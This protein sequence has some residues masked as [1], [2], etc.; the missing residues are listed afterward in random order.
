MIGIGT[1]KLKTSFFDNDCYNI[2]RRGLE[3][4]YRI[5]D[6]AQLY[7]NE[8][9]VA[10]AIL[11]SGVDRSEIVLI[12]KVLKDHINTG[13][14]AIINSV[15]S[16]LAKMMY[17]NDNYI[18][19]L[20]LHAPADEDE[21]LT[22]EAWKCLEDIYLGLIPDLKDKVKKIG[23]S[24]FGLR[25]LRLILDNC[26]VI[27]MFN[28]IEFSPFCWKINLK[29]TKLCLSNGIEIIAHSSLTKGIMFDHPI[30]NGIAQKHQCHSADVLI[31]WV[32]SKGFI[33]L[34]RTSDLKHLENNW[35]NHAE[36]K[37]TLDIEDII[38]LDIID[39]TF[40]THEQYKDLDIE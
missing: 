3:L 6:T 14:R 28:Q 7:Q 33:V 8:M 11:D 12:T 36:K 40:L 37:I 17:G 13:R 32:L 19:I 4:G 10:R 35:K 25:D 29:T 30:I 26:R 9:S 2:V 34:P 18:D 22:I 5:V 20:L 31:Q 27:P 1:Y 39:E 24:N 38:K 21:S 15:Y 16:S 23:V